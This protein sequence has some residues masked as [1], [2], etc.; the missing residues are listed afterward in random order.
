MLRMFW[1]HVMQNSN[2]TCVNYS[3]DT[4]TCYYYYYCII[5]NNVIFDTEENNIALLLN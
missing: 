1:L 5:I 4:D 3:L 2:I